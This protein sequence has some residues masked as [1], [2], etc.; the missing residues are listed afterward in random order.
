MIKELKNIFNK[1]NFIKSCTDDGLVY[2]L[3][4]YLAFVLLLLIAWPLLFIL[5]F[6][7][8][9]NERSKN[10]FKK[11]NPGNKQEDN[12]GNSKD[13]RIETLLALLGFVCFVTILYL[14]VVGALDPH[15]QLVWREFFS[16]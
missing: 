6:F 12:K 10:L 14:F 1:N 5:I 11:Q 16:L 3:A 9:I 8:T 7:D 13:H 4:I 15:A 2:T